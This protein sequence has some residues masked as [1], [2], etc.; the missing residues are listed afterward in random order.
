MTFTT[1]IVRLW[2]STKGL[3]GF[4]DEERPDPE[5]A[6]AREHAA[7][8][9]TSQKGRA[10]PLQTLKDGKRPTDASEAKDWEEPPAGYVSWVDVYEGPQGIGYVVNYEVQRGSKLFHKSMNVG[11]ETWR[12]Q[13][14]EEVVEPK[15]LKA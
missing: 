9:E 6:K 13:D 12:E 15:E 3:L 8:V 5:D 2:E 11:P 4:A 7:K 10:F 1:R 14:W